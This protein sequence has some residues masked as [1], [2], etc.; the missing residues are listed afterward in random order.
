MDINPW[1]SKLYEKKDHAFLSDYF[2]WY[3]LREHGGI[4]LDGDIEIVDGSRFR[5]IIDDLE[6]ATDHEAVIGIDERSGGW[7]TAHSMA[8]K[9]A[10]RIADFMCKLYD[11][12]DPFIP[13]RKR[14]YFFFAPQLTALYFA[15]CGHN[16]DGLGASPNLDSPDVRGGVRI[17][18][19]DWFSPL[20]P[21]PHCPRP[22]MLNALTE[23]STLCHHF[24]CSWH[25]EGSRY[26]DHARTVGG[27]TCT[28]VAD[29]R[30]NSELAI[31]SPG[32][33]GL[34][35]DVGQI[36]NGRIVSV[37]RDCG[38]LLFGPYMTLY[39]GEYVAVVR[40]AKPARP[41]NAKMDV[42]SQAGAH[43][44]AATS[45]PW[46]TAIQEELRLAFRLDEVASDL[47]VRLK[48]KGRSNLEIISLAVYAADA[49]S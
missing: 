33:Q 32:E 18:P 27:Q 36:V 11:G 9:P 37:H 40:L 7:Y 43:V 42:T 38:F 45:W 20:A 28:T 2:R 34:R 25:E 46:M 49:I 12:L 24:A 8:A 26:L 41:R 4:Y 10:S 39:P 44:H 23:N 17:L 14:L 47:E 6:T 19:Q 21:A 48:V 31:F 15:S 16:E 35:T 13:L 30:S 3:L 29:I 5:T 1:V 22:F